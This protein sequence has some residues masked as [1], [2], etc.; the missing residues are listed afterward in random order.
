MGAW[1]G[2]RGHTR[3]CV[4]AQRRWWLHVTVERMA[5]L[6]TAGWLSAVLLSILLFLPA[7]PPFPLCSLVLVC[8]QVNP[9]T[10]V[11]MG[12]LLP[13]PLAQTLAQVARGVSLVPTA[14]FAFVFHLSCSVCCP[15]HKECLA[16]GSFLWVCSPIGDLTAAP[17]CPCQ[18]R[19]GLC[20]SLAALAGEK[21][22]K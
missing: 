2:W 13:G 9:P 18:L 3:G 8:G 12:A 14:L 22:C 15:G 17:H 5:C 7:H 4:P 1:P 6:S 21:A 11:E 16:Q 20:V 10:E 19:G